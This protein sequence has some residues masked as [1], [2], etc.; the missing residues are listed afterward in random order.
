MSLE[1]PIGIIELGD[2]N[3]KCLIFKVDK[4]NSSKILSSTLTPSD[5]IK[6]NVVINLSK[7]TTAIRNAISSAEKKA[8]ISLKKINVVL[9]QPDFLCTKF[10]KHKKIDGSQIYRSDIEFLLKEAKKQLVLNDKN[11]SI[12]HIFNHSY[13]V[14]GKIF[15]DEPINVFANSLSHEMTFVTTSKNNIKNINQVFNDCDIEIERL[16]SQTFSLGV[17]LLSR[18]ELQNGSILINLESKKAS[19]GLFKNL[20]LLHSATIPIGIDHISKDISKVF[21]LNSEESDFLKKNINFLFESD[22]LFDENNYL[23][24]EYFIQS[25]YRKISKDLFFKVVKS[26]LDEYLS[27]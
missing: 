1:D 22:N 7:A 12:I 8:N 23:K 14:D 26:R 9:E 2:A 21:S 11:Q 20:A 24:K 17:K 19:I 13:I 25:K 16:M 3:L 18:K 4:N 5:G 15:I 27:F 6:N 10:S